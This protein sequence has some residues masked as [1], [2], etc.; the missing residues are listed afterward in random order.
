MADTTTVCNVALAMIGEETIGVITEDTPGARACN[1]FWD[2]SRDATLAAM[3]WS[4]ATKRV[5][6]SQSSTTPDFGW[7][8]QYPLPSDFLEPLIVNA[9]TETLW[10]IEEGNLL[11][12]EDEVEFVY[13]ARITDVAKWSALFVDAFATR[14]AAD[15]CP[16]VKRD[17]NLQQKLM[18]LFDYKIKK[19]QSFDASRR[20]DTVQYDQDADNYPWMTARG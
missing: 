17:F 19:A 8:Y 13:T 6:L 7:E 12:N 20:Y 2:I 9:G 15:V 5:E 4:F 10:E 1:T 18:Q 14:L 16:S 11:T 3:H